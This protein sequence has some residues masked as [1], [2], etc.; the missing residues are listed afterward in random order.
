MWNAETIDI[1][2]GV[3]RLDP[4]WGEKEDPKI[5][6]DMLTL[7]FITTKLMHHVSGNI[8]RLTLKA[9]KHSEP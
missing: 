8:Y 7:N 9:H 6:Q 3:A 1:D 5:S 4:F 2:A